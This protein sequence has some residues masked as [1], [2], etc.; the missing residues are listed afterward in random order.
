[1][2]LLIEKQTVVEM[3]WNRFMDEYMQDEHKLETD[4]LDCC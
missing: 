3:E 4:R 2:H 1:M